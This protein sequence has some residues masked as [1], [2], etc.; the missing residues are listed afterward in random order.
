VDHRQDLA[1]LAR[2]LRP[3]GVE[4]GVRDDAAAQG[5]A[6]DPL[7]DV[8]LAQ[9]VGF[10]VARTAAISAASAARL[11]EREVSGSKGAERRRRIRSRR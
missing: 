3:H 4:A 11:V 9:A 2:Q 1:A 5:L 7:G 8:G 6:G 10:V